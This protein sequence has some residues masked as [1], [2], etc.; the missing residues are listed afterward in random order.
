MYGGSS[1]VVGEASPLHGGE[2]AHGRHEVGLCIITIINKQI[3]TYIHNIYI[4]IYICRER[5][6]E[7][8]S[9]PRQG[10]GWYYL[11]STTCL[12]RPRLFYVC[13]VVSGI[14]ISCYMIR[15]F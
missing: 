8:Y 13:F 9:G 3:C 4:Y 10:V 5:E 14:T 6:R 12:M 11:S 1:L 15:H 2:L 7:M